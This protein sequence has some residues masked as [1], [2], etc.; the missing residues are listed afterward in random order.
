MTELNNPTVLVVRHGATSFNQGTDAKSRLKGTTYD[1]PLTDKGHEEAKRAA[2]TVSKYPVGSVRHSAMLRSSQT[3]RHVEDATGVKSEQDDGLD[4]WDI[5]YMAGLTREDAKRRVEYY[6][7]NPHKVVPE[8]QS[9]GSWYD[10]YDSTLAREMRQA[11]S[12]PLKARVLVTHSCNAA[13]TPAIIE[14]AEPQFHSEQLE[15]PGAITKLEKR[16]GKWRM[17][18]LDEN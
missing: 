18:A 15:A 13:A 12:T 4:P 6:I 1:L 8:G 2:D 3:A 14:G 5:G 11:E 7:R 9:Y 16:G 17:S 10:K